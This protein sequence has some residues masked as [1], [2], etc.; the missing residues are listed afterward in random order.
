MIPHIELNMF[1]LIFCFIDA[2]AGRGETA[3]ANNIG[4][5]TYRLQ[6]W[7]FQDFQLP[8]ISRGMFNFIDK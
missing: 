5:T 1:C 4:N 3:V 7:D 8:D 2:F 6:W